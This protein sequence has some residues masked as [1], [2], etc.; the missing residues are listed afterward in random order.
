MN[1]RFT[2]RKEIKF[3]HFKGKASYQH[4]IDKAP[5]TV[6]SCIKLFELG[7]VKQTL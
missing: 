4:Q 3:N 6:A 1:E 2:V 5:L 7:I